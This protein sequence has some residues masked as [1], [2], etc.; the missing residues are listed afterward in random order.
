MPEV[1]N[2]SKPKKG[3][4]FASL[5]EVHEF[6]NNNGRATGFTIKI[7]ILSCHGLGGGGGAHRERW[8]FFKGSSRNKVK[9]HDADML[10]EHFRSEQEENHACALTKRQIMKVALLIFLG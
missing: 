10:H 2:D 9:G 6:Y 1:V 3:Q 5:D 4:E 7:S 8:N